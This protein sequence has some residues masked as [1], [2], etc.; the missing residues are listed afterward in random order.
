MKLQKVQETGKKRLTALISRNAGSVL[1][2][3]F[4]TMG[5]DQVTDVVTLKEVYA[6]LT[7][8]A[9]TTEPGKILAA[10]ID[11]LEKVGIAAMAPDF[12]LSTPDG[13]QVS[14]YAL[15]GKLKIIDFWASCVGLVGWKLPIW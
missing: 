4:Q 6:L 2:A 9:K 15:K 14:L 3:Y 1:A 5:L 10:R 7:D 12:T 8:A 13:E 11:A